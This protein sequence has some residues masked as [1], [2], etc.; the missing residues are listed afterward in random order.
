MLSYYLTKTLNL[1]LIANCSFSCVETRWYASVRLS[2]LRLCET[3]LRITFYPYKRAARLPPAALTFL[4]LALLRSVY[5]FF[6][7]VG[8]S[9][10]S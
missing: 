4:L 2:L 5:L 10:A 8:E 6:L 3:T 1:S 9:L 7:F